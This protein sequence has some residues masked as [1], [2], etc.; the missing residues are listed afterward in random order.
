MCPR[1]TIRFYAQFLA[2]IIFMIV[3]NS[4][5][6]PLSVS[7][8]T[9]ITYQSDIQTLSLNAGTETIDYN[10]RD[11]EKIELNYGVPLYYQNPSLSNSCGPTAGAIIVGYYDRYYENLIPGYTS[12]FTSNLKYR[13]MDKVYVPALMEELYVLMR[14]NVSDVG[15]S[16]SDCL[17]GLKKYVQ[18]KSLSLSYASIANSSKVSETAYESA[19]KANKPVILFNDET[20]L[21]GFSR[22]DSRDL[23]TVSTI[24]GNHIFVGYGYNVI[25]YRLNNGSIRKDTYMRVACGLMLYSEGYIRVSSTVD[26]HAGEWFIS[27]YAVSIS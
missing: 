7:D 24:S 14:T 27:G 3:A 4:V 5:S 8:K 17:A 2:I 25:T 20:T 10:T 21:Y 18:N 22:Q 6:F 19:I 11:E 1:R 26:S 12:Y 15:V 23:L 9:E 16:E 13:P